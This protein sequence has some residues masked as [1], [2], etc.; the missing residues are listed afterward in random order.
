MD[1]AVVLPLAAVVPP[2][3]AVVNRLVAVAFPLVAAASLPVAA[4]LSMACRTRMPPTFLLVE[5]A[6]TEAAPY[7]ALLLLPHH[8]LGHPWPTYFL[9]AHQ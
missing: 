3:A 4:T 1:P 8:V 7:A 2:L 5:A 9:W 6:S